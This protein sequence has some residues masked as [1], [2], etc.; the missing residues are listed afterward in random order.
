[1]L[2]KWKLICTEKNELGMHV[3]A[4]DQRSGLG[5]ST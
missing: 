2:I 1:M 5:Q 4:R 3:K